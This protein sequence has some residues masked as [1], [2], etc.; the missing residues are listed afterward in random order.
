M[1]ATYR[2]DTGECKRSIEAPVQPDPE[3]VPRG[4]EQR[5]ACRGRGRQAGVRAAASSSALAS[6]FQ[7][8]PVRC[9]CARRTAPTPTYSTWT[10]TSARP[11]HQRARRPARSDGGHAGEHPVHHRPRQRVGL[12]EV[13][14]RLNRQLALVV[15]PAQSAAVGPVRAGRPRSST[16]LVAVTDRCVSG[17]VPALR[18]YDLGRPRAPSARARRRGRDQR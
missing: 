8:R 1:L 10:R 7:P 6:A 13:L 4:G 15:G 9:G 5:H 14:V 17:V 3:L 18:T 12:G 16:V 11:P 2:M